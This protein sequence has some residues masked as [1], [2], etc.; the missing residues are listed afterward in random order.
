MI[1]S[2][3][4]YSNRLAV[5]DGLS[6]V[7]DRTDAVILSDQYSEQFEAV[8]TIVR[9]LKTFTEEKIDEIMYHYYNT[10][11]LN[12][13]YFQTSTPELIA[14][15]MISVMSAKILHESSGSKFFP[16][17][18][19]ITDNSVFIITRTSVLNRKCSENYTVERNLESKYFN[20]ADTTKP[21]WRM[22][23]FRST[24]SIFNESDSSFDRLKT[25]F[26]Q[27]PVFTCA[28]PDPSELDL[29]KLLDKDFYL[30]KRNT[31]TEQIY[32]NLNKK[33]VQSKTGLG[34][35]INIE[36]RQN[37]V[38]RL[39]I[40]FKRGYFHADL[41]SR[42][43]DTITL[44]DL[45]SKSKYIDP[46]SNNV[47][48]L[49][50][51][52]TSLPKAQSTLEAPLEQ[53][54]QNLVND[55]KLTTIIPE[56]N[57]T[58]LTLDRTLTI[59][60][61]AYSYCVSIFIQHFSGGVGPFVVTVDN[62]AKNQH[63]SPSELHEIKS[64]LKIQP[65]TSFRIYSA[66]SQNIDIIK[67]L[68]EEFRI[69]H[70][71]KD[72]RD[73][74]K[75]A[76][77]SP[78]S[79]QIKQLDNQEHADILL[80]FLRFNKYTLRT[81]F[82]KPDKLSLSFRFDSTFLKQSDYPQIPYAIVLIIGPHFMGFHIR[83][84][85]ISRGGIRVVQ[86]FSQE[87]YT[88]NKLQIFDEA[89]NLSFTQSL[90]NKD[91]PE[92]G[93]KGVILLDKTS[94]KVLAENYT[95]F[96]FMC[97][98]DGILDLMLP[99]EHMVDHLNKDEI[100]FV[101]PDEHTGTGG[102]MD[103]AA[104]YAKLRG[105]DYWR[106]FTTGKGPDMGG[107]PHDVYG[108]TTASIESFVLE[109]FKK[110]GL[111]ESNVTRFLT[112]GPDGDLG[113]NALLASNTRTLSVVDKSGVLHDPEGLDTNELRRL[114]L[115]RK[116]RK[117]TCSMMYNPKLLSE[118][119]FM[120]PEEAI[121]VTL[122]DG[123][124]VKNGYKFRDNFHLTPYA[125]ADLFN[126]CGGRPSSITP[127]NVNE[128]FNENNKCFFKFIVEG[129]NVY[130]TQNARRI[131]E[132]KGVV[133]F[134]DAS[135]NKGGVTSSSYEVLLALVLDDET[136]TNVAVEM[137][138]NFPEF[139]KEY[140]REIIDIIKHNARSEFHAL[141]NEGIRT[142]ES[143]CDLTDI[144]SS[145]I[146]N[147]KQHIM[148]SDTLWD[149]SSFVDYVLKK[150][151]PKSLLKLITIEEIKKRLPERYLRAFFATNIASTFYYSQ[152][153]SEETSVFEFYDYISKIKSSIND[154][155]AATGVE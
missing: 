50:A 89:Y 35:E 108:M 44:Y 92:G 3:S 102:L 60:E 7:H 84:S 27:K 126:P 146:N 6:N 25:Y 29:S 2:M 65:Y 69:R 145:K 109:L 144:L 18:E 112:G 135:T 95:R 152:Q 107:I 56:S 14:H 140:I 154:K 78:I 120:V 34:L 79:Q 72:N 17:I 137:N 82:F 47:C 1:G 5:N 42:I 36:P 66:I 141:W 90:K 103:W 11:G 91:I 12:E 68:Y 139:R 32:N 129:S 96:S 54:I 97:Y 26:L 94:T 63:V 8:Q 52:L 122:P 48:I 59:H 138:G 114:A 37:T 24:S 104:E 142:G 115:L 30:N 87:A 55:I 125:V 40:A 76:G 49:T 57:I 33:L 16:V 4:N 62:L 83:F 147:L 151:I 51:F 124:L 20:V 46:L 31:I 38:Y 93:S 127:F 73:R 75:F 15:N 136:F 9:N 105:C 10:L 153:F 21:F 148:E 53:R 123:T 130:I 86:S 155:L 64:K 143:R 28:N 118:K 85:E 70:D 13:Y 80:Y 81:N 22:Q 77:N 19:Q 45:Y 61:A 88:R 133:L 98:I 23:C 43:G 117:Q 39:D 58:H 101:G 106:A 128:I 150:S 149:D 110:Y 119:G 116:E 71:P 111:K 113:S 100:Y 67:A 99:D 74:L 134:K 132:S 131:L 121:D 41:Y